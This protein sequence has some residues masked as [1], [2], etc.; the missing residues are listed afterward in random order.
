MLARAVHPLSA[1]RPRLGTVAGQLGDVGEH[2]QHGELGHQDR[3][4]LAVAGAVAQPR[5]SAGGVAR[6]QVEA[7]QHAL[8]VA[9]R[10]RAPV[11]GV[12]VAGHGQ[13]HGGAG[14][15]ATAAP[16]S[17]PIGSSRSSGAPVSTW[18]PVV[19]CSS[20]TRDR[21]RRGQHRLHLHRLEH[22]HAGAGLHL[23]AD[24]DGHSDDESRCRERTTP[25][26]SRLTRWVTPSTSTEWTV[27]CV[28]VTIRWVVP[29]TDAQRVAA[30]PLDLDVDGVG[31]RPAE[32]HAVPVG[33]TCAT[34]TRWCLAAQGEVDRAS[35]LVP[36]LG[37]A[38]VG[39]GEEVLPL[40]LL[41]LLVR[42]DRRRDERDRGVLVR[43]QRPVART[44]SIHPVSAEPST[45]SGWSSRSSTKL[46]LVAPPS[47]TTV[48]SASARRSRASASS[49]SRP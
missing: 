23:V 30:E 19:T 42:L 39:G 28:A 16:S 15:A 38:A 43:D 12:G 13:L 40:D 2:P 22:Q 4:G 5:D 32:R 1:P 9:Q 34:V 10:A 29:R 27:P 7:E 48:V 33:E 46:L 25:P 3:A 31:R 49:R 36:G 21:L 17:S 41:L 8:Q 47:M 6:R 20:R 24:R 14:S 26:S 37:A 18:R 44:R 35:G 45:T 11:A